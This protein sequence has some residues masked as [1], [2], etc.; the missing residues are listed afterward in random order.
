MR[1]CSRGTEHH[2][3]V[4]RDGVRQKSLHPCDPF[5]K[6]AIGQAFNSR[7]KKRGDSTP[8]E[9]PHSALKI[10]EVI[11]RVEETEYLAG[12]RDKDHCEDTKKGISKENCIYWIIIIAY[13]S[14]AISV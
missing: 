1:S 13:V 8:S 3:G 6:V 2:C 7:L 11:S 10:S 5:L 9:F 12:C 4:D 14:L